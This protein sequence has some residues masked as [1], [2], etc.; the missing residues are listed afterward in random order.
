MAE[1]NVRER[2]KN[3]TI[4]RIL[5]LLTTLGFVFLG[6]RNLSQSIPMLTALRAAGVTPAARILKEIFKCFYPVAL[7]AAGLFIA[8][9]DNVKAAGSAGIALVLYVVSAVMGYI[10]TQEIDSFNNVRYPSYLDNEPKQTLV[11]TIDCDYGRLD[12]IN[13]H[14]YEVFRGSNFKGKANVEVIYKEDMTDA[15]GVEVIYRGTPCTLSTDF[16]QDD[17]F[18]D[19]TVYTAYIGLYY[20]NGDYYYDESPR[21]I[22]MMY[23]YREDLR[24]TFSYVIEKLNI[25]TAYPEMFDTSE[26][27]GY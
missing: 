3:S 25:Y 19:S 4:I 14:C 27:Y 20:E 10:D 16:Y 15:F 7:V 11:E 12:Q 6:Y 8:F 24:Y 1:I 17:D 21:H 26:V 23:K 5:A 9:S 2:K 22:A 13:V 18:I